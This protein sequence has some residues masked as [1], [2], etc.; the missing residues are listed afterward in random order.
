MQ[1]ELG[2]QVLMPAI[3]SLKRAELHQVACQGATREGFCKLE[4]VLDATLFLMVTITN[5]DPGV[6]IQDQLL[7]WLLRE[8]SIARVMNLCGSKYER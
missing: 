6:L 3:H 1:G 8:T 2:Q 4:L 5:T 7:A